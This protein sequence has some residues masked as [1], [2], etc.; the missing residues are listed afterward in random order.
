MNNFDFWKNEFADM[1]AKQDGVCV[2]LETG[3]EY[4]SKINYSSGKNSARSERSSISEKALQ[5]RN[6]AKFFGGK[7]LKGTKKQKEWAEKIRAQRIEKGFSE[8]ALE[9]LLSLEGAKNCSFWIGTR[10]KTNA[11]IEV[12]LNERAVLVRKHNKLL[13]DAEA[14][15]VIDSNR[16]ILSKGNSELLEKEASE[17]RK[18]I[19][20]MFDFPFLTG[21]R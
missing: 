8:E 6:K 18:K 16:N 1:P 15:I 21:R 10:E 13:R 5:N 9:A 7:A 2:D 20:K 19:G 14:E 12:L 17:I 3:L 11:Q 4:D